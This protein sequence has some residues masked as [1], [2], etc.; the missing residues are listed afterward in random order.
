LG[1]TSVYT[2]RR[3]IRVFA[4][5]QTPAQTVFNLIHTEIAFYDH[6]LLPLLISQRL[7]RSFILPREI[8][9]GKVGA[10]YIKGWEEKDEERLRTLQEV[11]KKE[12]TPEEI[13]NEWEYLLED[14]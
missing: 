7:T 10:H 6:A 11:E 5:L 14:D 13:L 3:G 12:K 2:G 4:R 8:A 1:H 9:S